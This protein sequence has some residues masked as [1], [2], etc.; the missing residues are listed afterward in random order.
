MKGSIANL[1]TG[2]QIH[3][4]AEVNTGAQLEPVIFRLQPDVVLLDDLL[5]GIDVYAAVPRILSRAPHTRFVAYVERD[6]PAQRERCLQSGIPGM[7]VR[8]PS[9]AETLQAIRTVARGDIFFPAEPGSQETAPVSLGCLS[10]REE[11]VLRLIVAGKTSR[12]I[13]ADLSI[14]LSTV[15]THK[16]NIMA[17]LGVENE[18]ALIKLTLGYYGASPGTDAPAGPSASAGA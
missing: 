7:L 13:A 15:K 8:S 16:R 6:T 3:L 4:I 10:S 5:P 11:Y 14:S 12:Q 2:E 1:K 18:T 17:K 9:F